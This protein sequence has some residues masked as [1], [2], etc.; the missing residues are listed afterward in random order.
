MIPESLRQYREQQNQR[1]LESAVGS[2]R[3]S[4]T[5]S[6]VP[7]GE[8]GFWIQMEANGNLTAMVTCTTSK[9]HRAPCRWCVP[10]PPVP[11]HSLCILQSLV[12]IVTAPTRRLLRPPY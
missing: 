12:Q 2:E 1:L 9:V 5:A 6:G 7:I 10:H 11:W 8:R 3:Q 4:T